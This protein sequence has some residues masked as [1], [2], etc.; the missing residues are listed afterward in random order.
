MLLR[1]LEP[2]KYW[3]FPSNWS[4]ERREYEIS[5]MISSGCYSFQLKT[6]GN[7]S[8]FCCDFDGDKRL[9]TRGKSVKTGEY[10]II[11]D[12]VFFFEEGI[13]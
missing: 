12:K 5:R 6:D 2:E 4:K 11:S 8:A 9:I 1:E 7:Y 13:K 10:G 3:S